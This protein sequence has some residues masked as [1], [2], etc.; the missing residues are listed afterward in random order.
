[1]ADD[2]GKTTPS[3]DPKSTEKPAN[4]PGPVKPP[5]LE[6]TARP[7]TAGKPG[8]STAPDKAAKPLGDRPPASTVTPKPRPDAEEPPTRGGNPWL[9]G[10]LGGAIGLGAAYG[11]AWYGLWPT[12]PEPP[13][14][15]DPRLAEFATAIPELETVT[16]T[17]QDELSTLT[18]R[19]GALE[20]AAAET[21]PTQAADT[22]PAVTEQLAALAAR[23]D[24]LA[25]AAAS[26]PDT[27][28]VTGL[29][30]ELETLRAETTATAAQLA[31]ANQQLASLSRAASEEAGADAATIR[32]PLIFS[33]LES[34]FLSGRPFETELAA[35]RQALPE[36][37][38]PEA[39]AGRAAAGLPQ[40]E[41]VEAQLQAALPDMLAGRP[42]NADAAWQ[43]ATVDWFRGLVA[44]RPA[45][46][47][48][49]DS[50]DAIIARLEAAVERRD[51]VAA[52]AELDALPETMRRGAEPFAREIESLGAA[53]S[54]LTQLRAQVLTGEAGA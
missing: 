52:K 8:D 6:G 53:Q 32:L 3:S 19:V 38:V 41:T 13:V 2:T 34:A 10:L 47:V 30:A 50:P 23:L 51:F 37:L 16:S 31:E 26:A 15:A 42:A 39:V 35:L 14:P 12:P 9:A 22:D 27:S 18:G 24:E 5:V 21:A 29:E 45:G 40:P 20:T 36:T 4:K 28:A 48:E 11:L 44:M 33:G 54:F 7:G 49:G 43:D 25:T 17:V 46:A 1:M